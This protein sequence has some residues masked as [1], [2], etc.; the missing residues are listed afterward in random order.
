VNVR[1]DAMPEQVVSAILDNIRIE[2]AQPVSL[3]SIRSMMTDM[4][5]SQDGPIAS[6]SRGMTAI[7]NR[8]DNMDVRQVQAINDVP[9]QLQPI[10]AT[11]RVHFWPGDDQIH[12]VP[13]GFR[14]P[15]GKNT[16]IMWNLW[17]FGE[18][19]KGI[20]P[21]KFIPPSVDLSTQQCKTDRSRTAKVISTLVSIT[22]NEGRIVNQRDINVN[23]SIHIF[24]FAFGELMRQLYPDNPDKRGIDLTVCSV[25]EKIRK[26]LH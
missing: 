1:L 10:M 19:I 24:D 15:N 26:V 18:A 12:H 3:N 7:V 5:I 21:Y 13:H 16:V 20:G 9:I 22:V 11:G 2:G 14:W 17:F 6:L 23:N 8:L 25:Y 4:L